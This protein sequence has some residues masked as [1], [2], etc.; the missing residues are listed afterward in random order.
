[1]DA[2]FSVTCGLQSTIIVLAS[3]VKNDSKQNH[4]KENWDTAQC[5][6]HKEL[7]PED[8][9][10]SDQIR[11]DQ[12][13]PDQTAPTRPD[14]TRRQT[15]VKKTLLKKALALNLDQPP[16]SVSPGTRAPCFY[17]LSYLT[18]LPTYSESTW[19]GGCC[20]PQKRLF[21]ALLRTR[22]SSFHL[23]RRTSLA[24]S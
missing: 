2:S 10:R 1:M 19:G 18:R 8:Q 17:L 12:T 22:A 15:K 9:I 24:V 20:P 6:V 11:P 13:R 23:L 4:A 16:W 3:L 14:Q 7:T 21:A 5:A